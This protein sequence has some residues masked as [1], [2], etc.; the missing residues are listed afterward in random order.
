MDQHT[1]YSQVGEV[2]MVTNQLPTDFQDHTVPGTAGHGHSL[3]R[4]DDANN[5]TGN[6]IMLSTVSN[7][8]FAKVKAPHQTADEIKNAE[9][10]N[11]EKEDNGPM[12]PF[13]M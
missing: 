1:G 11:K 3:A 4:N 8:D 12:A 2:V 7:L 9:D 13:L 6:S 5:S 10:E